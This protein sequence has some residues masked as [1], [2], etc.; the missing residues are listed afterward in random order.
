MFPESGISKPGD[1]PING[2]LS[3]DDDRHVS[4]IT[5]RY[6]GTGR[7]FEREGRGQSLPSRADGNRH[8][9][10]TMDARKEHVEHLRAQISEDMY[11]VDA[12]AVADAIVRRLLTL[13]RAPAAL[14][15]DDDA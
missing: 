15:S 9:K 12:D 10:T 14:A 13:R 8:G 1:D 4:T 7:R 3:G 6:Q 2:A 5:D 11:E